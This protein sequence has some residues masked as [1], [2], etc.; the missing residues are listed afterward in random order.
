ME[1]SSEPLKLSGGA[2][3][4]NSRLRPLPQIKDGWQ[5]VIRD[6]LPQWEKSPGRVEQLD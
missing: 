5:V 1:G 3:F 4:V 6:A 2:H